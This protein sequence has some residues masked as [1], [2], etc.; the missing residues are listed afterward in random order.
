VRASRLPVG[1][2]SARLKLMQDRFYIAAALRE[3]GRLLAVKGENPF[4]A[5]AYERAADTLERLDQDIGILVESRR[6]TAISGVGTALAAVIEEIYRTGHSATLERL[7]AEMPPGVLELSKVP[8]VSLKKIVALYEGLGIQS[9]SDLK[10]ACEKGLVRKVKGFGDKS[11]AKILEAINTVEKRAGQILLHEALSESERLLSYLRSNPA[12]LKAEVTGDL[13]RR[14]EII[15]GI[16]LVAASNQPESVLEHFSRF[17]GVVESAGTSGNACRVQLVTGPSAELIAVP[18][19]NY[20]IALLYFTGSAN[21]RAKLEDLAHS[22]GLVFDSQGL[23]GHNGKKFVITQEQDIY[24]HLGLQYIPS[25]LREDEGEIE[26][27]LARN[28]PDPVKPEDVQGIIHCHT[29]YSDGANTVEEMALAAE[30]M[31]MKYLTVTDHSPSAFYARGVK[32]DQLKEQWDEI[33]RVQEK[34]NIKLL[35]GTESDILDDGALDYPEAILEQFDVII[36]SIHVRSGM[37]AD[38]MT[39]RLVRAMK[40]PVFKIWGHPLGRLLRSRPPLEC[41]MEEVLDAIA[42]SRAAIEI[43]GNP[44]RLDLEPRWIRAARQR[45]IRFVVSTDAHS[46]GTL[47]NLRYAVAMARRGWLTRDEVLN[48]MNTEEFVKAVH[49]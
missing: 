17:P 7:R 11:E 49:P 15:N 23:R 45:G 43:N 38:E 19:E 34:V 42:A 32:L 40:L 12:V 22:K 9:L 44:H 46:T 4:K 28:L 25:E 8:G 30:A 29:V 47:D 6:L 48:T 33:A 16:Q 41:H 10:A 21:H 24:R 3:I 13:R 2:F 35:R 31:G 27:A 36:A 5:Q 20:T 1:P 37:G 39:R 14:R 26:A 18:P